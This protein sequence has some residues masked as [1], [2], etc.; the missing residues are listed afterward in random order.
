MLALDAGLSETG[1]AVVKAGSSR[2]A[3]ATGVIKTPAPRKSDLNSRVDALLADLD[4]LVQRWR[5]AALVHSRPSGIH[6]RVPALVVLED[7]LGRW[8]EHR[9]L[10]LHAYTAQEVRLAM[11][12]KSNAS[13]DRLTYAVMEQLGLIGQSKTTHEW[14]ALA[15]GYYHLQR[16]GLQAG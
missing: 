13:H 10:P 15:A 11:T 6:W 5:P 12:G 2:A 3:E 4:A 1:W 16:A 9:L 7:R 8:A 14:E